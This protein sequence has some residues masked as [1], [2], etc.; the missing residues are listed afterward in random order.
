MPCCSIDIS[1]IQWGLDVL[2]LKFSLEKQTC[3]GS[4]GGAIVYPRKTVKFSDALWWLAY[5]SGKGTWKL[6]KKEDAL[7]KYLISSVFIILVCKFW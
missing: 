1:L 3:I 6:E 5:L 4:T 2:V 7:A